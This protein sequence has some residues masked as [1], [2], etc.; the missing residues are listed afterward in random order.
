MKKIIIFT[1]LIIPLFCS[2]QFDIGLQL[3][4]NYPVYY[5]SDGMARKLG[6]E[7]GIQIAKGFD[8][9]FG[10]ETGLLIEAYGA[11]ETDASFLNFQL[12]LPILAS[13]EIY[14]N[15]IIIKSGIL[16]GAKNIYRFTNYTEFDPEIS[17]NKNITPNKRHLGLEFNIGFGYQFN[18]KLGVLI[19]YRT[20]FDIR[21]QVY[22]VFTC[23]LN[24]KIVS[25]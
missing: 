2:A 4:M 22:G 3:G 20:P 12:Y 7:F 6:S 5:S 21:K 18:K 14:D 24:Y 11:T 23:G 10:I 13:Y 16:I 15:K 1:L 8:N 17:I 9:D 19:N 25:R